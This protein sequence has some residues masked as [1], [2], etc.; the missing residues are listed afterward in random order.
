MSRKERG[1]VLWFTGLSGAGK[2]TLAEAV[3]PVL[4]AEGKKVESLDG[5]VVRT[6]LSK[7]L[8][9]SREDRELNVARIAWVAHLLQRNG[10]FVLVSAISP[11]RSMRDSA[12]ELIAPDFV[13][14]H[15]APPLEECIK[16]DV[17]GLYA[18]AMSGEIKEFTGISDPYEA[19]ERPELTLDTSQMSIEQGVSRIVERLRELSLLSERNS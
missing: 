2:S 16:R 7:G 4:R 1:A 13:E 18:K 19:P 17:K 11:Y 5:D 14:I 12:R 8:G 6:H 15:V 3:A 10:V 9:F